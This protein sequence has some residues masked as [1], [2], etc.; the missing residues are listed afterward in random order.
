MET[1]EETLVSTALG[2]ALGLVAY[3]SYLKGGNA[4]TIAYSIG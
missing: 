1:M 4:E 2:L 3:L